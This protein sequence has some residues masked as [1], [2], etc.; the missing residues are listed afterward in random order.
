MWLGM[1]PREPFPHELQGVLESH[2]AQRF[3]PM[4]LN[5]RAPKPLLRAI[6]FKQ[7]LPGTSIFL[8]GWRKLGAIQVRSKIG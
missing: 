7:T 1:D 5:V 6:S 4:S 8:E 3:R 2:L